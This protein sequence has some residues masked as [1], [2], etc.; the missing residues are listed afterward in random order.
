MRQSGEIL[1][2]GMLCPVGFATF[3][4]QCFSEEYFYILEYVGLKT[5]Q[6]TN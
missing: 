1:I 3:L 6:F 2:V 4:L 5:D